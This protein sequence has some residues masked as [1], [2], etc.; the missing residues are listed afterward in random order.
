[1]NL[2]W[3]WTTSSVGTTYIGRYQVWEWQK[4]CMGQIRAWSCVFG[5]LDVAEV[6]K[7]PE[8]IVHKVDLNFEPA[9]FMCILKVVILK[10]II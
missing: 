9:A 6:I 4:A 3:Q 2:P 5:V 10:L 1:M 7:R 8:L